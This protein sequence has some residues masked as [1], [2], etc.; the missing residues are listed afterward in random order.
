MKDPNPREET[1]MLC[2]IKYM[3]GIFGGK[4]KLPII[5]ILEYNGPMRFGQ[6]K[7]RLGNITAVMLSQSLRE[8][9]RDNI[10]SRRQYNE[11][12]PKVEYSITPNGKSVIPA[13]E[14]I[15]QWAIENMKEN[16]LCP[17]C[18]RCMSAPD[19]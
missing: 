7:K 10:I 12:P 1:D 9:E 16:N 4:W 5:C 14:M 19:A 8:L 6:I 2:P 15:G 17:E 11:I 18:Q 13:L 3:L